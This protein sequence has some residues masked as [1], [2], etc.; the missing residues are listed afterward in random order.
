MR[1]NKFCWLGLFVL[2]AFVLAAAGARPSTRDVA[3]PTCRAEL[4][5]D[6][7]TVIMVGRLA[8][9][10]GSVMTTH[11]CDCGTCDWTFRRIPARDILAA[12]R[13]S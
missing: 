8:S 4:R 6:A 13:P 10:D 2:T 9:T 11:T 12:S 7:C 5:S 1:A 3:C